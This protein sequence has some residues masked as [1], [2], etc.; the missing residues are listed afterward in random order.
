[1]YTMTIVNIQSTQRGFWVFHSAIADNRGWQHMYI[2]GDFPLSV[3]RD[4]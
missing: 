1:M 2:C 4:I 3:L